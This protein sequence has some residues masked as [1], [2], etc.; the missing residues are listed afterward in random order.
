MRRNV[1]LLVSI[2][3]VW[4]LFLLGCQGKT[5]TET[6]ES[7]T[8]QLTESTT[9][10]TAV[11]T[12][13]STTQS[14]VPT[15]Q[16]T[17]EPI[18][19]SEVMQGLNFD[20][21][22]KAITEDFTLPKTYEGIT[23]LW[24]IPMSSDYISFVESETYIEALVNPV[25]LG[26]TDKKATIMVQAR[27][28]EQV[29]VLYYEFVFKARSLPISEFYKQ[30]DGQ[31]VTVG[32][33]VY[34][35]ARVG[36]DGYYI[37]DTTGNLFVYAPSNDVNIGDEIVINGEKS[38]YYNKHE[39]IY[40]SADDI[41]V[42]STNNQMPEYS[43]MSIRDILKL[44]GNTED[45]SLNVTFQA[46]VIRKTEDFMTNFYFQDLV[47][48]EEIFVYYRSAQ[49][50]A[51]LYDG[52][53]VEV[54]ATIYDFNAE[55]EK[56]SIFLSNNANDIV[57]VTPSLTDQEKVEAVTHF[58]KHTYEDQFFYEDVNLVETD[59]NWDTSIS[60]SSSNP[61]LISNTGVIGEISGETTVSMTATI[62]INQLEINEDINITIQPIDVLS[63][64][65]IIEWQVSNQT[66]SKEVAFEAIVIATRGTSGYFVNQN[67]YG[68]Y[69]RYNN[70]NL[71][72]GDKVLVVGDTSFSRQPYITSTKL[73][74]ILSTGNAL[75]KPTEVSVSELESMTT[76]STFYNS[77]VTLSG[78]I[79]GNSTP[80]G[81]SYSLRLDDNNTVSIHAA[82][83]SSG[84]SYLV[85]HDI[86]VTCFINRIN[87]DYS[88]WE[89]FV[90]NRDGDFSLLE[91]DA[92][93]LTLGA[94]Y[95]DRIFADEQDIT[96][97]IR[98]PEHHPAIIDI[99]YNYTSSDPLALSNEGK[100][101][102]PLT[103]V[104]LVFTIEVSVGEL[105]T[106][107]QYNY[108]VKHTEAGFT[109]DLLFTFLLHG[110]TNNKVFAI[111]NGT[112]SEVDLSKYRVLAVQNTGIGS[113]E[114]TIDASN[115]VGVLQLTG[116]LSV[117]ETLIVHH[118]STDIVILNQI[119]ELTLK[120]PSP[121]QNGVAQFNG[122]DGDILVLQRD[123]V[124]ID[125]IGSVEKVNSQG[126][127][128]SWEQVYF[129]NKMLIRRVLTPTPAL[130]WSNVAQ[131]NEYWAS[132][133]AGE[134]PNYPLP[135]IAYDYL[136]GELPEE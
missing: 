125:Q 23:L 48:G 124:V 103:D 25:P 130:D 94:D 1:F 24:S 35:K 121:N 110:I 82:S 6:T 93:K 61:L 97:D 8:T 84:F 34:A 81:T 55:T 112:D 21:D 13:E 15:T 106:T 60:W 16:T 14:T 127:S 46:K 7:L 133:P 58:L 107:K 68:Y 30:A 27:Y 115:V 49:D 114:Y 56:F 38:V 12:T 78:T 31:T 37:Y 135:L 96:T 105:S 126:Q 85:D 73:T 45:L 11:S 54:K 5:S 89:I 59:P 71:Q 95:L 44:E 57:E 77:Y 20:V 3:L 113:N 132:Y 86:E 43:Q 47:T 50:L 66:Q 116:T 76:S 111:Y 122:K 51:G 64:Q 83:N 75:P 123:S 134:A 90:V 120:Y 136:N 99:T 98:L 32:G 102:N 79:I 10:S 29:Q 119:P 52:K 104:N 62:S 2:V 108:V 42:Y 36:Y 19:I 28:G 17:L 131:V 87:S 69:V 100:Y 4:S 129:G 118:I 41:T 18:D 63:I 40:D 65:E 88:S 39:L 109:S 101:M 22:I 33:I 92:E 70:D 80:Y 128:T 91:S 72:P 67:G 9:Q 74:R 26:E 53:F 117:G